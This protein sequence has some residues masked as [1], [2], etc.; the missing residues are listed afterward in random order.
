M[1]LTSPG[2]RRS[3][4]HEPFLWRIA[5][6]VRSR[7]T[8]T[9]VSKVA[10][11]ALLAIARAIASRRTGSRR[12]APTPPT[13]SATRAGGTHPPLRDREGAV[14][15]TRDP[16]STTYTVDESGSLGELINA[17]V[18]CP[19]NCDTLEFLSQRTP[20]ELAKLGKCP[21]HCGNDLEWV[22]IEW[23]KV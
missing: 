8:T 3:A 6:E 2:A 21:M 9:V 17:Y 12:R 1:L 23:I 5:I 22:P 19:A 14:S 16:A 20:S 15:A 4:G 11:N 10:L 18:V 13:F 7:A